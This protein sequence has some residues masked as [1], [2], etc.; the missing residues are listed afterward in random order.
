MCFSGNV[1]AL[2]SVP[3]EYFVGIFFWI[4]RFAGFLLWM[5]YLDFFGEPRGVFA[6]RLWYFP[7]FFRTKGNGFSL[8]LEGPRWYIHGCLEG[9]FGF[10]KSPLQP[11]WFFLVCINIHISNSKPSILLSYYWWTCC[12]CLSLI[13]L[14]VKKQFFLYITPGRLAWW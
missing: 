13:S 11:P 12:W 8:F 2:K 4:F 9:Q 3:F 14:V 7:L 6:L 5:C 1:E 10:S